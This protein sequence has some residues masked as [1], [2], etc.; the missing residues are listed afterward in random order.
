MYARARRKPPFAPA[1]ITPAITLRWLRGTWA[2]KGDRWAGL[3]LGLTIGLLTVLVP[4]S[5]LDA[6][7]IVKQQLPVIARV[8]EASLLWRALTPLEPPVQALTR[9]AFGWEWERL[10]TPKMPDLG[11]LTGEPTPAPSRKPPSPKAHR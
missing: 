10:T 8:R 6:A 4:L 7:P 2:G 5:F 3:A 1:S 11:G 9:L